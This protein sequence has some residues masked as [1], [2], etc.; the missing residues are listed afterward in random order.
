MTA[1]AARGNGDG[2]RGPLR[3]LVALPAAIVVTFAVFFL[4]QLLIESGKSALTDEYEGRVVDFVRVDQDE[5][6]EEK[7]RKPEK[8]PE[9]EKPPPQPETPQQQMNADVNQSMDIGAV[10]INPEIN[11]DAGDMG[12]GSGDGE[13]LPIVKVSPVYPQRALQRGIEGWVLVEF[14]VTTSGSTQGIKVVDAEPQNIFDRAAI[15]AAQK[16]KYKPRVID[17]QAVEVS[18]VQ[19]LIRFELER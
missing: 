4:M 6:V 3:V 19:N 2:G 18:G 1:A 7:R 14:T 13:Y 12:G 17:G 5:Q 10:G 16:F 15:E 11:V 9:P 8:P